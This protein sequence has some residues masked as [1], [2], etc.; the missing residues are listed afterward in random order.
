MSRTVY[1]HAYLDA[2]PTDIVEITVLRSTLRHLVDDLATAEQRTALLERQNA[3]LTT[4]CAR[5]ERQTH[6]TSN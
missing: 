6:R 2:L 1:W 3:R 5:L 4:E